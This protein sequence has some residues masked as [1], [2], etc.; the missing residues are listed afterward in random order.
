MNYFHHWDSLEAED[1]GLP[2]SLCRIK[3]LTGEKLQLIWA[4]FQPGGQYERH[5]HPHEQFSFMIRGRM[6]LYVGDQQKI[7]EPGDIWYAPPN[8]VH[9]GDLLGDEPVIFVDVFTPIREEILAEMARNR[10]K[11]LAA[12]SKSQGQTNR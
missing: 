6:R 10:A 9:G 12:E 8:V 2:E 11:R 5:S 1:H 4:I 3:L 7:V